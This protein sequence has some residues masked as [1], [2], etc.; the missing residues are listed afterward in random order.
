MFDSQGSQ[1]I[2]LSVDQL[3]ERA[4]QEASIAGD[5]GSADVHHGR[6][7]VCIEIAKLRLA[8]EDLLLKREQIEVADLA[9]RLSE[10]I[11]QGNEESARSA[12]QSSAT[13]NKATEQLARSTSLL[14]KA[15]WILAVFTAIQA[16]SAILS[17]LAPIFRR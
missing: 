3:I 13:M 6:A 12:S 15:T 5:S 2:S 14:N 8:Q 4:A 10:R 16:F 9:N 7:K 17:Q 1:L 11:L